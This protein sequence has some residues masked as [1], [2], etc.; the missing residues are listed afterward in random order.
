MVQIYIPLLVL[1]LCAVYNVIRNIA[2]GCFYILNLY[3]EIF[4]LKRLRITLFTG[5][6]IYETWTNTTVIFRIKVA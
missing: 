5:F 4:V 2:L 6:A 3:L 1:L